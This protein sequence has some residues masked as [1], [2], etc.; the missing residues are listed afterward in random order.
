MIFT[1]NY[2]FGLFDLQIKLSLLL[3]PIVFGTLDTHI[4]YRRRRWIFLSF[5]F[6]CLLSGLICL[7]KA[8][9]DY[10]NDTHVFFYVLFSRFIHPAYFAM[11]LNLALS[12][13]LFDNSLSE[14]RRTVYKIM[15]YLLCIFFVF[16]IVLLSSKIGL[17]S[18]AIIFI[19]YAVYQAITKKKWQ[20]AMS[21]FIALIGFSAYLVFFAPASFER[22]KQASY[23]MMS[24][25]KVNPGEG[26]AVRMQIWK[27]AKE[28]IIQQPL[29]G[30]GTGDVK[31]VLISKYEERSIT[32]AIKY[33]LNAHSQYLQSFVAT[34]L[35]GI[36]S[37]L[38]MLIL[39]ARQAFRRKNH[40]YFLFLLIVFLNFL[41][42]SM[43]E[44]QAGVIFYAFFNSL[45]FAFYKNAPPNKQSFY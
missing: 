4:L 40:L 20:I 3:L 8:A 27:A 41:V 16:L 1:R 25:E 9:N 12:M 29:A 36:L 5:I 26:T 44:T 45:L 35:A 30:Y 6:A 28:L 10:T 33:K 11:Y 15:Y 34:G 17:I 21:A 19:V 39:P 37:L 2:S 22:F 43:L 13:L 32:G 23:A 24:D 38:L 42:E 18:S 14:I 31:D 7:F